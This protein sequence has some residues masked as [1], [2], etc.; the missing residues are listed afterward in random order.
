[1]KYLKTHNLIGAMLFLLVCSN[2]ANATL[3]L[4]I[5]NY[6]TD[7]LSFTISGTFDADTIGGGAASASPGYLAIKN[8]WSNNVGVHTE[9]FSDAVFITSNTLTIGTH[10]LNH[11]VVTTDSLPWADTFFSTVS[12]VSTILTAGTPVSGSVTL[13]GTGAIDPAHAATLQLVSTYI[14]ATGPGSPGHWARLEANAVSAVPVPAAV[15]L[16]GSAIVGLFGFSRRKPT[17]V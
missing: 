3:M 6:T 1:M 12:P 4:V 13:S 14:S 10:S 5:D 8:D 9:L 15:W 2:S 17:T 7:E 11:F 16:M